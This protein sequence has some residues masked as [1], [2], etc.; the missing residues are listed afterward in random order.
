MNPFSIV[1]SCSCTF[2]DSSTSYTSSSVSREEEEWA[3]EETTLDNHL[4]NN[5]QENKDNSKENKV[6]ESLTESVPETQ[7]FNKDI[8]K[9]IGPRII[10][11]NLLIAE[12][13]SSNK[14]LL[15]I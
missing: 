8:L 13:T 5:F 3:Y 11:E 12:M 6:T 14:D 15:K 10:N 2:D 1:I 7:K 9:S 4:S